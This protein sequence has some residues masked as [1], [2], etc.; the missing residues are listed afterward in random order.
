MVALQVLDLLILGLTRASEIAGPPQIPNE[1]LG[2]KDVATETR[3]P[4]RL[5][6]RNTDRV[7]MLL[8]LEVRS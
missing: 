7:F 1:Y 2:F 3:H 4:I 5:Y 8:R 6:T